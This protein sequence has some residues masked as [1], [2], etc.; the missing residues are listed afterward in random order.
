MVGMKQMDPITNLDGSSKMKKSLLILFLL[1]I[2][3]ASFNEK[4]TITPVKG[5]VMKEGMSVTINN[6]NCFSL[7]VKAGKGLE[8]DYTWN[9]GTRTATLIPRKDK[10]FGSYGAYFPG[11]G[12]HWK[13]HDG[14]TRLLANE[15]ILDF[16]S[17]E[18]LM[19]AI[20]LIENGCRKRYHRYKNGKLDYE[21]TIHSTLKSDDCGTFTDDG[22]Y[23]SIKKTKGPGSGGTLYVTIYQLKINGMPLKNLPGSSQD[24]IVV[25]YLN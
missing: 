20:S 5:I 19:C 17:N 21:N 6:K 8:R 7:T 15:A 11:Q 22:L 12:H 4:N 10:W 24:R 18:Q 3:C 9:G 2:S 16:K 25:T 13:E 1:L 14:I 23:V